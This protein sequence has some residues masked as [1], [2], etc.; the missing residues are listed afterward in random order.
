MAK[1][2]AKKQKQKCQ[3]CGK[4]LTNPSARSHI[5]SKIHQDALKKK[6]ISPEPIPSTP[7]VS[8]ITSTQPIIE[9]LEKRVQTLETQL[10]DLIQQMNTFDTRFSLKTKIMNESDLNSIKSY[11]KQII[12]EGH[13]ISVDELAKSNYLESY[14]W[15]LVERSVLDLIDEDVFELSKGDSTKAIIGYNGRIS[16]RG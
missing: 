3:I 5:N 10:K 8:K 9:T 16:R 6:S 1:K 13:S 4:Y 15:N 2:G 11:L 14:N 7:I 12:P